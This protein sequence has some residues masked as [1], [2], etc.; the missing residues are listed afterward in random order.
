[1]LGKNKELPDV[2]AIG[3][4]TALFVEYY[5]DNIPDIFPRATLKALEKFQAAHPTLFK[6]SSE[7]TIDKHRKKL[8]DWLA[9]YREEEN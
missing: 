3:T 6:G 8:M 1:M 7:W 5:N 9:S 2:N 4:T